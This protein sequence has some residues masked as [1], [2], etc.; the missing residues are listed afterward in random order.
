MSYIAVH[1]YRY[2]RHTGND[3]IGP[4]RRGA[5]ENELHFVSSCPM[6][7]DFRVQF[8]PAKCSK[9]HGG[10]RL[11]QLLVSN[12]ENI[13]INVSIYLYRAFKLLS[14]LSS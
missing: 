3:L 2:E 10:F 6:L 12:N 9:F 5:Q 1:C 14:I 7:S 8:I 4:L 11:S 13:V